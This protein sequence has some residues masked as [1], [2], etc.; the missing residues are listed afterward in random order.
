MKENTKWNKWLILPLSIIL[1]GLIIMA[2]NSILTS[3]I[4]KKMG[5]ALRH[6]SPKIHADY[7]SIHA[8]LFKSSAF[9]NNLDIDFIPYSK[10]PQHRHSLHF[11]NVTLTGINFFKVI[12]SS[13]LSIKNVSF[14]KAEIKLDP[15][16]LDKKDSAQAITDSLYVPFRNVAIA[17]LGFREINV[18]L[19]APPADRLLLR[20]NIV[21]QGAEI[22]LTNN[23][24]AS[25]IVRFKSVEGLLSDIDYSIPHNHYTV[26]V[27]KLMLNSKKQKLLLDSLKIIS[28]NN[29]DSPRNNTSLMNMYLT[30]GA[31][32]VTKFNMLQLLPELSDDKNL[33]EKDRPAILL[34]DLRLHLMQNDKGHLSHHS[35]YCKRLSSKGIDFANAILH[36]S[37]F[38]DTINLEGCDIRVDRFLL[39]KIRTSKEKML[40]KFNIP[41][42]NLSINMFKI[43]ETNIWLHSGRKERL[44]LKGNLTVNR[45]I[46][47]QRVFVGIMD[48]LFAEIACNL[49]DIDYPLPDHSYV[50][51]INKL[52]ADSKAAMLRI[53]S[54]KIVPRYNKYQFGKRLDHQQDWI[55]TNIGDIDISKLN[56]ADFLHKE[57]RADKITFNNCKIYVFRDRRLPR[58][59]KQQPMPNDY[60]KKIPFD[61]RVNDLQINNASVIYEEF[62]KDGTKSGTLQLANMNMSM[63]PVLNHPFKTDPVYAGTYITGSIMNSG[64]IKATIHGQLERNIYYIKGSIE[65]LDLSTLNSSAENLGKFHIKSGILNSLNFHFTATDKKSSGE[66]VGEYHNLIIERLKVRNGLKKVAKVPTFFLKH[67]IIPKNK[68]KSMDVARRTGKIDYNRDPTRMATFYLLKSLLSGIRASFDLG[69]LLPK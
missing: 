3:V 12:F 13:A 34:S 29:I 57:L 59:L 63:S 50:M 56:Y 66:I 60:L 7:A 61:I 20:G 28:Q 24:G 31:M 33:D 67:L 58:L 23:S 55:K 36:H 27:K 15:F 4:E 6:L 35:I 62:P 19:H 14:N 10:T 8:N 43:S 51:H 54:L 48:F 9:I 22:N 26:R 40:S 68:D 49:S 47:N 11:N 45:I 69:F 53:N 18:W 64:S 37:L 65:N 38:V 21:L 41:F 16:L 2:G 44:L 1:I 32:E 42:K 25:N 17:N 30:A 39:D 5:Q 46:L 52:K